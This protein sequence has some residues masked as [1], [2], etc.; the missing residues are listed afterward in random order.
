M[1]RPSRSIQRS[2]AIAEK[3]Q[4]PDQLDVATAL[5]SLGALYRVRGRYAEAEPLFQ[6]SLAIYEKVLGP[7]HAG[8]AWAL[9][10]LAAVYQAQGRYLDAEPLYKRDLAIEEKA[11]GADHP[12]VARAL[13]NLAALAF[14][15]QDWSRAEYYWRRS[16]A[17]LV[18]R[19]G[20]DIA[21]IGRAQTGKGISET[22]QLGFEFSNLVKVVYRV[23]ASGH[24]PDAASARDTFEIAQW[25]FGSEA[26]ASLAQMAARG[27]KAD[28]KL[29]ALVRERQDLAAEWQKR[30]AI[31]TAAVAQ[32]KEKRNAKV[33][34]GNVVRLVAIDTRISAIDSTLAKDFP[35]YAALAS[36]STLSVAEVQQSLH[37]DEALVLTSRHARSATDSGGDIR[38]GGDQDRSAVGQEQSR[39]VVSPARSRCVTLRARL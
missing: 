2:L 35:D 16:T 9:N 18:R 38:L 30:D 22:S 19:T 7:D 28:V 23:S 34:A 5:G 29:A 33:E 26:A 25:A 24:A 3:A 1:P 21:D 17:V 4:Q 10:N 8:V 31:R 36:P 13:N 6:R 37:P 12:D 27:A 14:L 32:P 20:R 39:H 11:L 15:Q